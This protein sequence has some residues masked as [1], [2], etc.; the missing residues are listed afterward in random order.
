MTKRERHHTKEEL[1]K[2][3]AEGRERFTQLPK[4]PEPDELV[5]MSDTSPAPDPNGGRD[6]DTEWLIRYG[7]G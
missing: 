5:E 7:A 1:A 4:P 3:V 2:R 6:P